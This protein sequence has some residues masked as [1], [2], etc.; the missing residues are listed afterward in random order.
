MQQP[1]RV[2][3]VVAVMNRGGAECMIMNYYRAIDRTKVQFDFLV[4]YPQRG[5]FD[6]EIEAMGGRIYRAMPIRPWNY[7]SYFKWLDNFFKEHH[8]YTAVHSHIQENSGFVFKYAQKYGIK[9]C[10][11]NSHIA[12]LSIDYKFLFREFAK[13]YLNKYVVDRWACGVEAGKFLYGKNADFKVFKNAVKIND[14]V[15]NPMKDRS[16]RERLRLPFDALVVGNVARFGPQKNHTFLLD[17]FKEIHILKPNAVLL[18][19]GDGELRTSMEEKAQ[20]LGLKDCVHFLGVRSDVCEI[21]QTFNVFLFPSLYEGLPVSIIEAQAAG[22]QIVLSDTIDPQ[23]D[24]TGNCHFISLQESPQ[25]WACKVIEFGVQP[26][27]STKAAIEKAGYDVD[28]NVKFLMNEYN[29]S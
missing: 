5:T 22:L 27:L 11:A 23:T 7:V 6:D 4:H 10:I 13:L 8:G 16:M 20:K 15:Y 14:F 17:I 26:R 12:D 3:Q 29:I 18:L 21:M 19:C 24:V 9:K 28:G 25:Q 1:S 2:L